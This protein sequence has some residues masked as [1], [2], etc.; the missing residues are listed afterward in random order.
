M[1]EIF[2]FHYSE[3]NNIKTTA[4]K[5]FYN[6]VEQCANSVEK[7]FS[8]SGKIIER[9]ILMRISS[10]FWLKSIVFLDW[11]MIICII[12]S[13]TINRRSTFED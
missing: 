11:R 8:M 5:N 12:L 3:V 1:D 9:D 10:S 6:Q 2:H 7:G 4:T 13:I